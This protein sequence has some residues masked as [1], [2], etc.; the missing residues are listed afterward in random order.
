MNV[1]NFELEFK[2]ALRTK[3]EVESFFNLV[4]PKD[5]NF[6]IFIPLNLAHKIL[7]SKKDSPLWRQFIPSTEELISSPFEMLDPIGDQNYLKAPKLIHRYHNRALFVPTNI[8]PVICRYCFRKNELFEDQTIFKGEFNKTLTYLNQHPEINEI[9]FSGGDPLIL[10]NQKL[11]FYCEE[12]K[13]IAHLKHIRFHT[14]TPIILP[15]R[16][17]DDFLDL[18][19]KLK[20]DFKTISVVIHLNHADE[21]DEP[22]KIALKKIK[23]LGINLLSQSV[24]LKNVND[25]SK[26]LISLFESLIDLGVI[27]YYLHHPDPVKGGSHFQIPISKGRAIFHELRDRLPGWAI[28]RYI[29]DI[30]GGE[31]KVLLSNPETHQFGGELLSKNGELIP[32]N[33]TFLD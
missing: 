3:S 1:N 9:I 10:S 32:Y 21:L 2:T 18:L 20:K 27:P 16:I 7:N 12:F 15:S 31:G 25:D 22:N 14:R 6:P 24:L 4:L 11:S 26:T 13:K 28:P 23:S 8:C 5:F 19:L 29:L 33:E 17:D 30:P